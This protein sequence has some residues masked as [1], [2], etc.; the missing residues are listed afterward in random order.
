MSNGAGGDQGRFFRF[1]KKLPPTDDRRDRIV[2]SAPDRTRL[3]DLLKKAPND[4][5]GAFYILAQYDKN[6]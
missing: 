1:Y 4:T 3:T 2:A 5:F 6:I